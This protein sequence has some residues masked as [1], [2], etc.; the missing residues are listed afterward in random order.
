MGGVKFPVLGLASTAI[1][2]ALILE[3]KAENSVSEYK[4][5]AKAFK[6][7]LE[8]GLEAKASLE[9]YNTAKDMKF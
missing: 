6:A 4:A 5:K 2:E 8:V 3:A 7:G 1:N 9:D